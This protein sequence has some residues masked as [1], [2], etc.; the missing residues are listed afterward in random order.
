MKKEIERN[1]QLFSF[2]FMFAYVMFGLSA[3]SECWVKYSFNEDSL[4]QQRI[5]K[6]SFLF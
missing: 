3:Y 1:T 6:K 5:V 2:K 4:K